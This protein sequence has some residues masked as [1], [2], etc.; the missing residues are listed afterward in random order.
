MELITKELEQT[1]NTN[2]YDYGEFPKALEY[3]HKTLRK[4]Q[5]KSHPTPMDVGAVEQETEQKQSHTQKQPQQQPEEQY[6][7]QFTTGEQRWWGDIDALGKGGKTKGKG[8]NDA[9]KQCYHCG[10]IGH[11]FATC[12]FKHLPK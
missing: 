7:C 3:V 2:K 9:N 4:H 12:Y 1:I 11:V 5:E 8:N 10:R 6:Q